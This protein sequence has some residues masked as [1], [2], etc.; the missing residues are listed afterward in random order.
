MKQATLMSALLSKNVGDIGCDTCV[1]LA[2]LVQKEVL[3]NE[4]ED[5]L[6]VCSLSCVTNRVFLT[7]SLIGN[8]LLTPSPTPS[9]TD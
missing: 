5:N 9:E 1:S 4:V 7:W 2:G 3:A 8:V 6:F